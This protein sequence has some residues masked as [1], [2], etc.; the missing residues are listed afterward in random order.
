[1]PSRRAPAGQCRSTASA[2]DAP[3]LPAPITSVRPEGGAGR[4]LGNIFSGSAAAMAARKLAT[5]NAF[6]S[7]PGLLL[8]QF[9]ERLEQVASR[10][11]KTVENGEVV[12]SGAGN[13]LAVHVRPGFLYRAVL[14]VKSL[15]L[16]PAHGGR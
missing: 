3:A 16:L 4:C 1:M 11:A 14:D 6:G 9:H 8:R 12:L 10:V 15:V 5:S 2:M 7:T 13:V